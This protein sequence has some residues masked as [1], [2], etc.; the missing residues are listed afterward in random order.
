MKI[1]FRQQLSLST[2]WMRTVLFL[3]LK[4]QLS[5][6]L[7]L[8][9]HS[10]S[11]FKWPCWWAVILSQSHEYI[12]AP[13]N[14]ILLAMSLGLKLTTDYTA[15]DR[16]AFHGARHYYFQVASLCT[17]QEM[18]RCVAVAI[19]DLQSTDHHWP[20]TVASVRISPT[21]GACAND[22]LIWLMVDMIH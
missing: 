19:A 16:N 22:T 1:A 10:H 7:T 20:P 12:R 8:S 18:I 13:I 15:D 17:H 9:C 21:I 11:S 2:L 5:R 6:L 3:Y 4:H 14:L